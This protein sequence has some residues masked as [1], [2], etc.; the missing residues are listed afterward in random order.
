[1]GYFT[2]YSPCVRC[3]RPF[4]YNPTRVPSVRVAGVREPLC[5]SCVEAVN[6][7]RTAKGLDPIVPLPG[8]YE[9]VPEEEYPGGD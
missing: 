2:V 4:H 7:L 6:V 1:M 8:A 5:L 3:R 9:A